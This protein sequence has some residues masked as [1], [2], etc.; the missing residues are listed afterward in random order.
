MGKEAIIQRLISNLEG[1]VNELRSATDITHEKYILDIRLQRFVERTLHICIECCF[2]ITSFTHQ[3][4]A[5]IDHQTS[6]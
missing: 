3:V 2:D 6:R 4:K 1:Y 5:W